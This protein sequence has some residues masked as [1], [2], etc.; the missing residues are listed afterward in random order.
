M[1]LEAHLFCTSNIQRGKHCWRDC[2]NYTINIVLCLVVCRVALGGK[3]SY[4]GHPLPFLWQEASPRV[5]GYFPQQKTNK[6]QQRQQ[7]KNSHGY[8]NK[9][10]ISPEQLGSYAGLETSISILKP[11][12]TEQRKRGEK[13]RSGCG[14]QRRKNAKSIQAVQEVLQNMLMELCKCQQTRR[15]PGIDGLRF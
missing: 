10:R 8:Q 1:N 4:I 3:K 2:V 12:L 14:G 6:Q 15:C 13:R 5:T 7:Q 9:N 11:N